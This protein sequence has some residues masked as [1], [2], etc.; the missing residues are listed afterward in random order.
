[1]KLLFLENGYFRVLKTLKL[2]VK[3]TIMY[4]YYELK[5]YIIIFSFLFSQL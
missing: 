1:M 4:A 3:V 2:M 5:I